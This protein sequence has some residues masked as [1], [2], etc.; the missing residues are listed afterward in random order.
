LAK[1]SAALGPL[2]TWLNAYAIASAGKV[3][4]ARGKTAQLDPPPDLAPLPARI[5]TALA[6]GTMK[7]THRGYGYI[8]ALY[9]LG[10]VN[11]D[12]AA[13]GTPLGMRAPM[14]YRR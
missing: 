14:I 11:P 5:A 10:V 1:Q 4:D 8:R 7:D 12:T 3:E 9:D 2:A 13:A 6:L